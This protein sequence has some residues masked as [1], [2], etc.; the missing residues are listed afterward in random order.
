MDVRLLGLAVGSF[1]ELTPLQRQ[2]VAQLE[3][4]V[5]ETGNNIVQHAY[6]NE[7]GGC[8]ELDVSVFQDRIVFVFKDQGVGVASQLP[9]AFTP[10]DSEDIGSLPEG[11]MGVY[12][13]HVIMDEVRYRS[14]DGENRLTL[15]KYF[16][17]Q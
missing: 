13:L 2:I 4:C 12:L 3:L 15:V 11:G 8:I 9:S 7:S 5:V 17:E 6:G 14:C 1:C 10:P 16:V